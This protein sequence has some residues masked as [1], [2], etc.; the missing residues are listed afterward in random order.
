MYLSN[1][2]KFLKIKLKLK[3]GNNGENLN[4]NLKVANWYLKFRDMILIGTIKYLYKI[5]S[6]MDRNK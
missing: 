1:V 5:L 6:V 3:L 2:C 4:T